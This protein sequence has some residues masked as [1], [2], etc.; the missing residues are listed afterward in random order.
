MQKKS[1]AV[2][3]PRVPPE[4]AGIQINFCKMP[5]CPNFGIAAIEGP[6]RTRVTT[7]GYTISASARKVPVL[8]CRR[9]GEIPPLKSNTGI[10]EELKRLAEY[11][12]PPKSPSCP[13]A[14]CG[15]HGKGAAEH[16]NLYQGFGK[17]PS[18]S[19]RL[20]CKA[21]KRTFALGGPLLRQRE[22]HKN[23]TIF[24]LL[25]NKTPIKRI[26]EIA[27]VHPQTVYDK[28]DFLHRQCLAFSGE[29]E[30][31]LAA[32]FEVKRLYVSVDRQDYLVNW[33]ERSDKRNVQLSAVAAADNVTSYVFGMHLNFDPTLDSE[34]VERE[35]RKARDYELPYPFRRHARLWLQGDYEAAV[36]RSATVAKGRDLDSRIDA[37]Y[38]DSETREDVEAFEAADDTVKLPRTG[39]QIHAEYTLYAHFQLLRRLFGGVGKVRF[40]LDQ[41]SAMRAACLAAF[42]REIKDRKAD[43]FYVRIAKE[44]TVDEKRR[45][46]ATAKAKF[47]KE[48]AKHKDISERDVRMLL[49]QRQMSTMSAR[50]K[51]KDRW[52]T[53]P[54][55]DMSEPEKAVCY[56]TDYG[57]YEPSHLAALYDKASLHGVDRF[58]MQVRRRI[59]M[60]ERPIAT[61][62]RARRIWHG[63]SAYNPAVIGKLLDIFRTYYNYIEMGEDKQTPA[64]RLGLAKGRNSLEDVIYFQVRDN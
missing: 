14:Q 48:C 5:S 32:G 28:I 51:W 63:Y 8:C 56:L 12:E 61:A 43:A 25:V 34:K 58:F 15:N 44:L 64:M 3:H 42:H 35:A 57:E 4:V 26:C 16:S 59:S 18:G 11:L 27:E 13:N 40:F 49:I 20:R 46:T 7:D 36:A 23:K 33:T 50:G 53:H 60:L 41:D 62:S 22:P 9:C 30:R 37:A 52:L 45:S 24:K 29:R 6:P 1:S 17:T 21:C 38:R 10:S 54:F 2:S 31:Q 47:Q 55:P 19:K 39:M